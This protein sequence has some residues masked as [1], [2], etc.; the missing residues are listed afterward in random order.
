MKIV[1]AS[2]IRTEQSCHQAD[3]LRPDLA[4]RPGQANLE[5]PGLQAKK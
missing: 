3:F 5:L 4:C 2:A 1:A